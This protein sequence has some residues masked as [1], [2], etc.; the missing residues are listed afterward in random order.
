MSIS[1]TVSLATDLRKFFSEILGRSEGLSKGMGGSM[2]LIDKKCGF[3][4]SVPIAL[5][6]SQ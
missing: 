4:G 5:E 6:L 1:N 3:Y 2:H